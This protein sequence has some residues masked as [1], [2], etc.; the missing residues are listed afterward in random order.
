MNF[1]WYVWSMVA[2]TLLAW[3]GWAFVLWQVNPNEGGFIGFLL[4]YLTLLIALIGSFTLLGIFF[5]V[6]VKKRHHVVIREVHIA[7]R[8]ATFMGFMAVVSLA[9]SAHGWLKWWVFLLLLAV[10]ALLEYVAL[11]IQE[12]R[13][14]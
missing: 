13:R 9:L 8:H 5:R 10:I 14:A 11:L 3:G 7:F 2:G 4:F 6:Y 1:V 12:G